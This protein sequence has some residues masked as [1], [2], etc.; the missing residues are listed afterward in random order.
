MSTLGY[1]FH[2]SL[3]L[4]AGLGC[5]RSHA[6]QPER[7]PIIESGEVDADILQVCFDRL[8]RKMTMKANSLEAGEF[9]EQWNLRARLNLTVSKVN[10]K[11][12]FNGNFEN[13]K[14]I[15]ILE[16]FC[17]QTGVD[18]II[19]AD[20]GGTGMIVDTP[21]KIKAFADKYPRT[22]ALIREYRKKR[23]DDKSGDDQKK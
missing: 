19:A 10:P 1:W 17:R 7:S 12:R 18:W 6:G 21:E 22:A 8:D 3:L 23:K 14:A 16:E 11:L 2:I 20:V 9:F 4:I 13:V 15:D 5:S